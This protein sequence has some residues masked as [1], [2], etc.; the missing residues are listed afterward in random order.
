MRADAC[1][2]VDAA[3]LVDMFEV[4]AAT[5]TD[6]K[7]SD[8]VLVVIGGGLTR[9]DDARMLEPDVIWDGDDEL[10]AENAVA[11]AIKACDVALDVDEAT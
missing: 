5:V 6:A 10:D 1:G 3:V 11:F 7:G 9:D 8:C 4:E 2:C